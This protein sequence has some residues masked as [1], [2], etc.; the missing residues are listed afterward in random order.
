MTLEEFSTF[1]QDTYSKAGKEKFSFPIIKELFD[2]I[3]I[4]ED[5]HLDTYEWTTA[6]KRK[7]V[8]KLI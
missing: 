7:A 3:N 4:R 1:I 8:K 6:F 2:F 5:D